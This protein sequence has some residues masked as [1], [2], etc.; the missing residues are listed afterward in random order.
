MRIMTGQ[1]LLIG[2]LMLLTP[3]PLPAAG[4]RPATPVPDVLQQIKR[5]LRDLTAD[6][7]RLDRDIKAADERQVPTDPTLHELFENHRDGWH[8]HRRQWIVQ[9]KHLELARDLLQ[10]AR[11]NPEERPQLLEQWRKHEQE[12][13]S[14]MARLRDERETLEQRHL[15]LEDEL[16]RREFR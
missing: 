9:E 12:F 10:R 11:A 7:A 13:E 1:A 4:K 16:V 15:H 14:E 3:L 5:Q 2:S 8:L 6:L